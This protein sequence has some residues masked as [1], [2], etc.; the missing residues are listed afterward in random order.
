MVVLL[1]APL[2]Y[3]LG[4]TRV[5]RTGALS[6]A[7]KI[8]VDARAVVTRLREQVVQA[9]NL[10]S[11]AH[12]QGPDSLRLLRDDYL[13]WAA[14]TER[15]LRGCLVDRRVTDEILNERYWHIRSIEGGSPRPHEAVYRELERQADDLE[16]L[17]DGIE[18]RR[19]RLSDPPGTVAFLDTHVLLHGLAVDQIIWTDV[20]CAKTARL[21]LPLR[22]IEELDDKKSARNDK[23]ATRA[24]GVLAQ[25]DRLL[26]DGPGPVCLREET[27]LEALVELDEEHTSRA[28][29]EILAC[30]ED[31]AR[32]TGKSPLL[33]T[34]D[35]AMRLRARER[36]L[37]VVTLPEKYLRRL[38]E[39]TSEKR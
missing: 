8:G 30:C 2:C 5:A 1:L 3:G 35:S 9:R 23:L 33:V 32:F 39:A 38:D 4:M 28:D 10:A 20:L 11:G 22:V 37:Q 12:G 7:L 17:A 36:G 19:I 29:H 6:S 21:V 18:R 14:V 34:T 24:R 16:Q 27:T 31:F 25:I 26:A 13:Y 15:H